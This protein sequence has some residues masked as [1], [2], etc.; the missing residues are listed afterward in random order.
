V[1]R[2]GKADHH[3]QAAPGSLVEQGPLRWCVDPN[4]VEAKPGHQPEV[5]GDL[6][7]GGELPAARVRGERSVGHALDEEPFVAGAQELPVGD[8]SSR[9]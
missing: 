7:R 3:P 9:R 5:L 6:A 2:P 8:D 1:L 4:G